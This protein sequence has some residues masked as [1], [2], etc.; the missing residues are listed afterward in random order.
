MSHLRRHRGV[1]HAAWRGCRRIHGWRAARRRLHQTTGRRS[2][3]RNSG[4][5]RTGRSRWPG[6]R[7]RAACLR[8]GSHGRWRTA[9]RRGHG[10]RGA[11]RWIGRC[12]IH[13]WIGVRA[14]SS[15]CGTG[16]ANRGCRRGRQRRLR[17]SIGQCRTTAGRRVLCGAPPIPT[18]GTLATDKC[19]AKQR[20]DYDQPRRVGSHGK[21][22]FNGDPPEEKPQLAA[23]KRHP[24]RLRQPGI[25]FPEDDEKI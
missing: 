10:R 5:R 22:P 2:A 11:S 21:K 7:G 4:E 8:I 1:R 3:W 12:W 13:A 23:R 24:C 16:C 14:I 18:W 6:N 15:H 19:R 9:K 20:E 25:L 17:S